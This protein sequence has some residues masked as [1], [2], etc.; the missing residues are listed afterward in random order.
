[1]YSPRVSVSVLFDDSSTILLMVTVTSLI[2]TSSALRT[3]PNTIALPPA[4][5]VGVGVADGVGAGVGV[6]VGVG[7]GVGEG[8]VTGVGV[9]V[10]EVAGVGVGVGVACPLVV[11]SVMEVLAVVD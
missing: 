6:L 1:M 4:A 5:G 2:C 11:S 8:D 9:G 7:E 3:N 10:G